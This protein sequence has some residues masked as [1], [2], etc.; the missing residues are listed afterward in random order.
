MMRIF[1]IILDLC[2]TRQRVPKKVTVQ[3]RERDPRTGQQVVS[4]TDAAKT[5]TIG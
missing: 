1:Q 4:I 5:K 2:M 3:N